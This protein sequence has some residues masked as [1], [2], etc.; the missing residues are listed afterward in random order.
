MVLV[1]INYVL[2]QRWLAL[3]D[4]Q[5][6]SRRSPLPSQTFHAATSVLFTKVYGHLLDPINSIVLMAAGGVHAGAI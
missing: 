4:A 1:R 5:S 2:A 6:L 3:E